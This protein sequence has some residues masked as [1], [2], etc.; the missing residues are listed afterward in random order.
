MTPMMMT[1]F[2]RLRPQIAAATSMSGMSGMTR[3]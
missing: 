3:K 1:M 2:E